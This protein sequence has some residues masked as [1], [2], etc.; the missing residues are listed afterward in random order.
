M[1][2]GINIC[3]ITYTHTTV[4]ESS[5]IRQILVSFSSLFYILF[6]LHKST[7]SSYL[8]LQLFL[9]QIYKSCSKWA[10][11]VFSG[12]R[13]V[14]K[15]D[16]MRIFCQKQV[17]YIFG[18]LVDRGTKFYMCPIFFFFLDSGKFY[19]PEQKMFKN[20][21]N[22]NIFGTCYNHILQVRRLP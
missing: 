19:R 7:S 6:F 15:S 1:S 22:A 17:L 20:H 3:A 9:V 2:V 14:V 8:L 10:Y 13:I 16:S 21:I 11:F 5:P 18:K 4:I 12:V